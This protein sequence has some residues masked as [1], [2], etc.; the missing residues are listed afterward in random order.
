MTISLFSQLIRDAG[1]E[2]GVTGLN[3]LAM[4]RRPSDESFLVNSVML[5]YWDKLSASLRNAD[6]QLNPSTLLVAL[7]ALPES[8]DL[9][10]DF[11]F[12]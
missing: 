5:A 8:R 7:A 3:K 9:T 4:T 2:M 10:D 11:Y 6:A 12:I 1:G